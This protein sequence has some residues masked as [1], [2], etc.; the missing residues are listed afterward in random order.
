M[1]PLSDDLARIGADMWRMAQESRALSNDRTRLEVY[2]TRLFQ[3]ADQVDALAARGP[4]VRERAVPVSWWR[5]LIRR[6]RFA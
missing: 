2:A 3:I 4:T 6:S 1:S 5:R